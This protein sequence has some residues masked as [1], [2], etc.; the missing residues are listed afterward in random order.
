MDLGAE[1]GGLGACV[2]GFTA[3]SQSRQMNMV[4]SYHTMARSG[5]F[6]AGHR[7]GTPGPSSRNM[8][9]WYSNPFHS[10]EAYIYFLKVFIFSAK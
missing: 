5:W 7:K 6:R 3:K 9:K 1:E 4:Y 8:E 10:F 2:Q